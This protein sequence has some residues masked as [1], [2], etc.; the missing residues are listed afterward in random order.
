MSETKQTIG[1]R[2]TKK[3]VEELEEK[4]QYLKTTRTAQVAEQINIARGFGDLS[5]NAEY[6]EAKNEQAALMTEIAR[7]ED[8]IRFADI[9]DEKELSGNKINIGFKVKLLFMDDDETEE[10]TLTGTRANTDD[11][12]KISNESPIGAAIMG[13]QAGD[14]VEVV[15]PSGSYSVKIL[16]ASRG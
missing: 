14:I 8:T 7:I 9:V 10:Y 16:E 15:S 13:K 12:T 4:L 11:I 6:E 1:K 3:E 2:M 5:E